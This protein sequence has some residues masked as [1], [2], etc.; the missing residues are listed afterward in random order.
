MLRF[1]LLQRHREEE[2]VRYE[3]SN[4][5]LGKLGQSQVEA[6]ERAGPAGRLERPVEKLRPKFRGLQVGRLWR[7]DRVLEP[8]ILLG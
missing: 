8:L 7:P 4:I 1:Q 6:L 3:S 2:Q 5:C